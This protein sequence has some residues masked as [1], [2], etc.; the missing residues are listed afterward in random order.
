MQRGGHK[1]CSVALGDTSSLETQYFRRSDA[2]TD[3]SSRNVATGNGSSRGKGHSCAIDS[4]YLTFTFCL[5]LA[6]VFCL[7]TKKTNP[8]T[9]QS[10]VLGFCTL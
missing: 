4:F 6:F 7:K 8:L 10:P 9:N 5:Y 2:G 1:P 3:G